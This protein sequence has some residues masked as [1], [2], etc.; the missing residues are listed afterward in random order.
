MNSC[1]IFE[2]LNVL[3]RRQKPEKA[4]GHRVYMESVMYD[5]CQKKM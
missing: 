3:P 2:G 5:V 1:E 4:D